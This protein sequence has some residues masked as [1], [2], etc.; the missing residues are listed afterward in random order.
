LMDRAAGEAD[1]YCLANR[2][3][4][5]EYEHGRIPYHGRLRLLAAALGV[6]FAEALAAA[7]AQRAHRQIARAAGSILRDAADTGGPPDP[8]AGVGSP[9]A[10]RRPPGALSAARVVIATLPDSEHAWLAGGNDATPTARPTWG[11]GHEE[12]L[13]LETEIR[14]PG[15]NEHMN[16]R[17]LLVDLGVL[18]LAAP[19]AGV[20]AVRQ[21]LTA[22]V[23]GDR[24]AADL[25][26]WDRIVHEYA[27]FRYVTPTDRLL[28]DLMADL[29]VL[30]VRLGG[31]D[32]TMQR[33][34]ARAG[35]QLGAICAMAW[36]DAGEPRRADRWW[37]TARQLADGSG[38]IEARTWVRGWEVTNGLY[39]QRPVPVILE[40]ATEATSIA[41]PLAS[42]GS[43][44][45]YGGLAQTLAVAGRPAEALAALGR[46]TDVTERVPARVVGDEG[47]MFGWPEVRLRHTES[48]VHTWL[49][50]T[51][52]A[53]AAQE[54]ALQIYPESLARDRATMLLHRVTC[55][56]RDG[57]VGGGLAYA[58]RV[59]DSLPAQHHTES[60]YAIGRAAIRVVPAQERG[61]PEAAE[62]RARLAFSPAEE[63]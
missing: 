34:L 50:D 3:A 35:A 44:H 45:L 54:A 13:P 22:A 14:R 2:Q 21:G 59:L 27:H 9:G 10:N 18:G 48:Y 30:Q 39:A 7:E 61:R 4:I 19:L 37:R 15:D 36:A 20:E 17:Q 46:V 28:R 56:I 33:G 51:C 24:H 49:G 25:D 62:L 29:S 53:Y 57:D 11:T 41:G 47:S 12:R 5:H 55:M 40:R 6:S 60:V 16:R 31:T 32:G 52:R 1:S 8:A 58:T 38:D 42:T 23:A 26:E 43:A 63:E